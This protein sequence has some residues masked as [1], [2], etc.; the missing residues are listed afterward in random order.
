M[1]NKLEQV[2]NYF[3]EICQIPHGSKNEKDLSNWIYKM[4]MDNGLEVKQDDLWNL[5]VHKQA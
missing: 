4:A 1:K 5:I 3:K 2:I